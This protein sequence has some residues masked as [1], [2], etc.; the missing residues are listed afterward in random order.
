MRESSIEAGLRRAVEKRGGLCLKFTSPGCDGV[1]D[2]VLLLPGGRIAFVE[3]KTSMGKL[4]PIQRYMI[5]RMKRIGAD[6]YVA[7]G[8]E[9]VDMVVKELF[10]D[11]V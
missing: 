2:R 4:S 10:P 1:P 8:K 3:L 11:G 9:G 7:Y 5:D 6:V